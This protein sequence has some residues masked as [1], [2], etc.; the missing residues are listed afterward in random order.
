M[1]T[2]ERQLSELLHRITP[3]PPRQVAVADV[4]ARLASRAPRG[5]RRRAFRRGWAPALAAAAVFAVAAA[6]VGVAA[7]FTSHHGTAPRAGSRPG[8]I[9]ASSVVSA[10]ASAAAHPPPSAPSTWHLPIVGGPWGA[11]LINPDPLVQDSLTGSGASLYAILAGHL[12]RIDPVAGYVLDSARYTE[13]LAGPPAVVGNTVWVVWSY[14]PNVVLHGYNATTLAQVASVTVPVAGSL[15]NLAQGVLAAG[16]GGSL[17]VAAGAGV[18]VVNPSSRRV[19]RTITVSAGPASSVAVS[20]DGSKLYVGTGSFTLLT[21]DLATGA[22]LASSTMAGGGGDLVAT[23]GG[24]WGT[25][26]TGMSEWVWFAPD[27]DLSRAVQVSQGAGGGL[28]SVPAF[29]GGAVWI[30]GSH[31]LV[32]A[33]PATGQVIASAPIPADH[34]IAEYLGRVTVVGGHA[35]ADYTDVRTQRSGLARMTPPAA[36]GGQL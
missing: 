2:G 30:G 22:Q 34:G 21:Y 4:A 15:S 20:P 9:S 16:P 19:V 31:T 25:T 23:P 13:P 3:E 10:S 11:E 6:S 35:Y 8:G 17:Y 29:S 1:N 7:L 32:C 28:E 36:C 26:G 18:A 5:H 27:G 14:G 33:D 12:V 24:V